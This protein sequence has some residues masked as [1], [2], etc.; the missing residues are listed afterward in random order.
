[1]DGVTLTAVAALVI[2]TTVAATGFPVLQA[3][4]VNPTV[5]LR[6]E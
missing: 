4:R 3:I 1:M 5:S 6:A 2:G